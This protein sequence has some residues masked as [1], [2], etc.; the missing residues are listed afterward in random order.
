MVRLGGRPDALI[1][2]PAATRGWSSRCCYVSA[3]ADPLHSLEYALL[4]AEALGGIEE[5]ELHDAVASRRKAEQRVWSSDWDTARDAAS[6]ADAI[7]RRT[8]CRAA[9]ASDAGGASAAAAAS[10]AGSGCDVVFPDFEPLAA[11]PRGTGLR[12]L[13]LLSRALRRVQA[14]GSAQ[15]GGGAGGTQSC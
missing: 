5:P 11:L 1:V 7:A 3:V 12:W 4:G 9:I 2:L 15:M 10:A 14:E 8:A 6:L 13:T